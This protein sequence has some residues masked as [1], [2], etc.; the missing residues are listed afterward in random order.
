MRFAAILF[1]MVLVALVLGWETNPEPQQQVYKVVHFDD[2]FEYVRF[3][4]P[5]EIRTGMCE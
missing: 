2:R 5:Q 3:C 1:I 4:Q